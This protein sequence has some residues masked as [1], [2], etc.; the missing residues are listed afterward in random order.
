[1][2]RIIHSVLSITLIVALG[3]MLVG[4]GE[5]V[6]LYQFER[7]FRDTITVSENLDQVADEDLA[8]TDVEDL[9][10]IIGDS[11]MQLSDTSEPTVQ[12]KI[13][14]IRELHDL[15][16]QVH[17]DNV[18]TTQS[19]RLTAETTRTAIAD[20]RSQ[21]LNLTEADQT[22]IQAWVTELQEI[23]LTLQSTI[24]LAFAQM[25]DL[26]GMYT[27]ENLDLIL[28][29]YEGVYATLQTRSECLIRSLEILEDSQLLIEG[30]LS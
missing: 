21:G 16:F 2:K 25:R 29:T 7:A 20:F 28:S 26:R 3:A 5:N 22:Q 23:K 6:S 18:N 27:L 15:I 12:E 11:V 14:R 17:T 8:S 4:C 9:A 24:G 10:F 19:I 30:Y 13:A 1:M